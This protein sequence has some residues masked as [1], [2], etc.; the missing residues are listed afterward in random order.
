MGRSPR[1]HGGR[2]EEKKRGST[3]DTKYAKRKTRGKAHPG[4]AGKKGEWLQGT[5]TGSSSL[6]AHFDMAEPEKVTIPFLWSSHDVV[7]LESLKERRL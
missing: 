3:K 5:S 6:F 7:V 1:R 2:G 4:F